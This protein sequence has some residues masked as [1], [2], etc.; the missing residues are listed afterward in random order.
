MAK[1]P[2]NKKQFFKSFKAELKKVTWPTPK[3]IVNNTS[4][5]ITV[6]LI[7]AVIVFV[8]DFVFD[9]MNKYGFDKIKGATQNTSAVVDQNDVNVSEDENT[10][11]DNST[12][13]TAVD[14]TTTDQTANDV[15]SVTN[16]E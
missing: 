11:N 14:N 8:L 13:N 1:D 5:V 15:N 16:T 10:S 12:D 9:S 3:Q 6:V 7:I 2:K 4:A